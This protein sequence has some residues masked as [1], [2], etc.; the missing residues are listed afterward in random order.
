MASRRA[1][2]HKRLT[3]RCAGA[4]NLAAHT[5]FWETFTWQAGPVCVK[6][7]GPWGQVQV[8]AASEAEGRRVIGAAGALAGWAPLSDPRFEVVASE[9]RSSR[10]GRSATM[11]LRFQRGLPCVSSRMGPSGAPNWDRE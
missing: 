9:V 6:C 10:Y 2:L 8:W 5:A 11:V 4:V 3:Y 7:E 1:K